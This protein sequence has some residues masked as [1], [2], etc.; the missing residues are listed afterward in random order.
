M[1]KD[2]AC[3]TVVT[4]ASGSIGRAICSALLADGRNVIAVCHN[5]S[6]AEELLASLA[7][8]CHEGCA[9]ST[10]VVELDD[11]ESVKEFASRMQGCHIS[12]LIN[13][14]GIMNRHYGVNSDGVESTIA[15]NY[16]GTVLLTKL[17]LSS[18]S[19]EGGSVVF[20]TS[21][22]RKLHK[23]QDFN[24]HESEAEFSQ[25]GTYG[26]SKLA[27]T[28]YAMHLADEM[29]GHVRVNCADPG[30]VNSKMITMHRWFDPIA[31]VLF[32]PFISSPA[33][34][35]EPALKAV[36]SSLTG[37]I[38]TRNRCHPIAD[39]L[40]CDENH[41]RLIAETDELLARYCGI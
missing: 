32:R 7:G 2:D 19:A 10:E 41:A 35:A 26:R 33:H 31:D 12:A 34:G 17:L 3:H 8:M 20:T 25:L 18:L 16:V 4:G 23:L 37:M 22:T 24:F 15:V 38:F 21:V 5:D 27:L 29:Y 14:A 30:V 1:S 13:N 9:L 39:E 36:S 28:H 40:A 6:R 11:S